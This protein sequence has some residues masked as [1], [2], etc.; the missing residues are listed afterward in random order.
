MLRGV[1]KKELFIA[2][3]TLVGFCVGAGILGLPYVFS[4]AGFLTGILNVILIGFAV[5]ILYLM[6]G[7]VSL[8][9]KRSHQITGYAG[10]YL[11]RKGKKTLFYLILIGWYG[12]I[13][14]YTIKIG[15]FLSA[16]ISPIINISPI[17][18]SILFALVG[19]LF[20]HKGIAIIEK[21]EFWMILFIII[22][23]IL[24]GI[25]S[26]PSIDQHNLTKFNLEEFWF[27]FGIVLFA[28][29][30]AGAI[31]EMRE[32]LKKNEK[33]MK[34]AIILGTSLSALAYMIFPLFVVGVTGQSTTDG[35]IIGLGN[36]LGYKMLLLGGLLGIL[37]MSTS[38]LAIGLAIKE[39]FKFDYRKNNLKSSL[40]ACIFP[41]I[42]ALIIIILKINNAFYNVLNIIGSFIYPLSGIMFVLIFWKTRKKG[43]RKPEY[44]L[45]F[46]KIL[47]TIIILLFLAGFINELILLLF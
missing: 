7:E 37:T 9:T 46:S 3:A 15:E 22:I 35:A 19:Y 24:I 43:D 1:M 47:G 13:I 40:L 28:F 45:K 42:I 6:L 34:P 20:V 10:K 16:L 8:R 14:A 2:S 33:L 36:V 18:Y 21:S 4:K 39:I 11:G 38:F 12:A 25:F 17:Y 26:M 31:P 5:T 32:E 27:P 29:G 30:A 23:F 44:S 41:F